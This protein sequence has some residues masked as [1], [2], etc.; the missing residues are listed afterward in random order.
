LTIFISPTA[1]VD[2]TAQIGQG[3]KVWDLSQIRE[4]AKIGESVIIGRSVYVGPAVEIGA[5]TKIQ[6][7]AQIYEP[8]RIHTGV[9][10]GPGVILTNDKNPRAVNP[11]SSQKNAKDW[12]STPVTIQTG[13]S[14]G[15][16]SV[17]VAPVNI[18]EWALV[19]AG[20]VVVRDVAPFTIVAGVPARVIGTVDKEGLRILTS[21]NS[22]IQNLELKEHES[23]KRE[24]I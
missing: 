20:S 2:P 23:D 8:A 17:L 4:N 15:A 6:N 9:F 10:I 22:S 11:D 12:R 13:A 21:S 5:N 3:S 18:G 19:A 1:Q 7:G 16:G 24:S 14:I